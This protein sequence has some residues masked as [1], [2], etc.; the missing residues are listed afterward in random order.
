[1][2][3]SSKAAEGVLAFFKQYPEANPL[4]K[5]Q[6]NWLG[7]PES[8]IKLIWPK[9]V[10]VLHEDAVMCAYIAGNRSCGLFFAWNFR[11]FDILDL[12]VPL[13]LNLC[14]NVFTIRRITE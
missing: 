1:M 11:L 8:I 5:P 4:I 10:T 12:V 14:Q 7:I 6:L 9:Y 3:G 13:L 2:E